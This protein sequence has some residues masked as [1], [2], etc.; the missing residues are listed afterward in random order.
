MCCGKNV[1]STPFAR[2]E[3]RRF[4][5][6]IKTIT[7]LEDISFHFSFTV[8]YLGLVSRT[9][10]AKVLHKNQAPVLRSTM[11]L[12]RAT[13]ATMLTAKPFRSAGQRKCRLQCTE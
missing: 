4:R 1:L 2:N 7:I 11:K 10:A 6:Q 8:R 13:T 5:L 3:S 12:L 9:F